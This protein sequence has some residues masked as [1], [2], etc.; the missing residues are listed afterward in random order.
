MRPTWVTCVDGT[1]HAISDSAMTA[2]IV[3][4]EYR[5]ACCQVLLPAAMV[6]PP[7]QRC[8]SCVALLGRIV[9]AVAQSGAHRRRSRLKSWLADALRRTE[10]RPL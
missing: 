5:T 2:G 8:S 7:R 4:G 1:E 3:S 10:I 6:E 9:A